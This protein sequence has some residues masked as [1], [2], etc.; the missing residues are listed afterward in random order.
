MVLAMGVGHG[1]ISQRAKSENYAGAIKTVR[2]QC[3]PSCEVSRKLG[4][5]PSVGI[6]GAFILFIV[7][8]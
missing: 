5:Q 2:G 7:V 3:L 1:R 4:P 8:G 6:F